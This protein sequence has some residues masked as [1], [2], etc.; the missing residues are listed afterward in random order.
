MQPDIEQNKVFV[1][2]FGAN[3]GQN[4][5][6]PEHQAIQNVIIDNG[7]RI[8][9]IYLVCRI[10]CASVPELSC[11]EK[12][13]YISFDYVN[14]TYGLHLPSLPHGILRVI[15]LPNG[16]YLVS[17]SIP[18]IPHTKAENA[19]TKIPGT[20]DQAMQPETGQSSRKSSGSYLALP[21]A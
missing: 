10:R 9:N 18:P 5:P 8:F 11:R 17:H 3:S 19:D 7:C 15:Y 13:V 1:Q 21:I 16:N 6:L 20:Q 2:C 4:G 12:L 14:R